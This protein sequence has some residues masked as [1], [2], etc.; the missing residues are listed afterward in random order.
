MPSRA[1]R[2]TEDLEDL[3]LLFLAL[4][5]DGP[6][7][8]NVDEPVDL[9]VGPVADQDLAGLGVR[10]QPG[11]QVTLSPMTVYSIRSSVPTVPATA[12]CAHA[13][14]DGD[15]VLAPAPAA[16]RSATPACIAT[17]S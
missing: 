8:A 10:L 5:P 17:A 4:D 7:R 3:D 13:D 9:L 12:S 11:R 16:A 1:L 6:E 15:R 2:Q 14:P